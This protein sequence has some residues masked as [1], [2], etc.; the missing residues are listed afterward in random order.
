MS[1]GEAVWALYR[2]A[3][4][5]A[6]PLAPMHLARRAARGKEDPARLDEKRGLLGD[7]PLTERPV[8]LH[9]VSVGESVAALALAGALREAGHAVLMTTG[10]P[11]A[12]GRVAASKLGIAH[13]YAPLDAPPFVRRFLDAVRPSAALFTESEVWPATID[14]LAR[15]DVPRAQIN[16]RMSERSFRRWAQMA[17]LSRPLFG[18]IP[19]ALAQ[20]EDDAARWRALGVAQVAVTGNLKFDA[21]PPPVDEAALADLRA[22]IGARP[23]WLAASIHPGEEEA[24]VAAH[25]AVAAVRADVVTIV[26]PRH[27]ETAARVM[28]AAGGAE[29]VRRRSAGEAP[30]SGLYLADTLGEM[31]TLFRLA[32]IVFLGAS[33]VPLGGHNPAEPAAYGSALLTGP[34][35][36]DMF[37]PFL[38]AGAAEIV[39]DGAALGAAVLRFLADADACAGMAEA[40]AATLARERGAVERTMAG[41]APVLDAARA[42]A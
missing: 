17:A 7:G 12:A 15:R 19:L 16:A 30:G 32:P 33:L 10:T 18:K 27:P 31:G 42:A 35:H 34:D 36:G 14:A 3:G 26:A 38:K 39:G 6:S 9:A 20:S 5:L 23:V 24:I 41:L 37:A 13:R 8:W 40:A 1:W 2:G 29:H 11:A 4:W 28:A 21:V 25:R 22:A